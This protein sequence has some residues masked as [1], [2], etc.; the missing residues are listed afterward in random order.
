[1][2]GYQLKA[3]RVH[4]IVTDCL[5]KDGEDTTGFIKAEGVRMTIGFHPGRLKSHEAEIERMLCELPEQFF[6]STGG[7]WTFLNACMDREGRQWGEHRDID[8]LVVLGI[9]IGRVKYSMPRDMW[10]I[11]PGGMPYFTVLDK[12]EVG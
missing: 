5:F 7:G 12:K 9:G 11:L 6:Q 3:E 4:A 2:T 1:M 8:G 10:N